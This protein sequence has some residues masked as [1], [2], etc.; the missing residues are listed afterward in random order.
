[1]SE[2]L[3][4]TTIIEQLE[5]ATT[6]LEEIRTQMAQFEVVE[7]VDQFKAAIKEANGTGKALMLEHQPL[8]QDFEA[9]NGGGKQYL[10][11]YFRK[12]RKRFR[13]DAGESEGYEGPIGKNGTGVRKLYI[14]C[15][16]GAQARALTTVENLERYKELIHIEERLDAWITRL[17]QDRDELIKRSQNWPRTD[18]ASLGPVVAEDLVAASP[19][20]GE[21]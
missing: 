17:E 6:H 16:E 10:Y 19:N 8:R 12:R 13:W 5:L 7:T 9:R 14:G 21:A 11:F 1:M 15:D 3:E 2:K 20:T 4:L 18:L